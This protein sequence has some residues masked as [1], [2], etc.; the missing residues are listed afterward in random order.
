[1][2]TD[3]IAFCGGALG[4]AVGW[5]QGRASVCQEAVG[6]PGGWGWGEDL[7]SAT[8]RDGVGEFETGSSWRCSM[9]GQEA[10]DA[11]ARDLPRAI[12]T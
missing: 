12:S 9:E 3:V 8:Q 5:A 7:K 6:S 2:F 11:W 10:A 1:M 4:I